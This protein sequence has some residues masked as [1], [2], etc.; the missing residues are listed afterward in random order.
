[1]SKEE[2]KNVHDTKITNKQTK[3][4]RRSIK[5]KGAALF[6]IGFLSSCYCP[7]FFLKGRSFTRAYGKIQSFLPA[8]GK[9]SLI[10]NKAVCF[11]PTLYNRK[12]FNLEYKGVAEHRK[13]DFGCFRPMAR[14]TGAVEMRQLA[15][16]SLH[17]VSLLTLLSLLNYKSTYCQEN[18]GGQNQYLYLKSLIDAFLPF[19]HWASKQSCHTT[20]N[21]SLASPLFRAL[22]KSWREK[23]PKADN[24]DYRRR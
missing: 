7:V 8:L 12:C 22:C 1:M 15:G 9:L 14:C 5:K 6:S 3:T 13:K 4:I 21:P 17:D 24:W 18:C 2:Y 20:Y 23:I 16:S 19:F 11:N 10:R